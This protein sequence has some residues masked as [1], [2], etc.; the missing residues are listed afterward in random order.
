MSVVNVGAETPASADVAEQSRGRRLRALRKSRGWTQGRVAS[1]CDVHV[2]FISALETD[3]SAPGRDLLFRLARL[4]GVY[5]QFIETGVQ[6]PADS[7]RPG[8]GLS[9][10]CQGRHT[11]NQERYGMDSACSAAPVHVLID[12]GNEVGDSTRKTVDALL[13]MSR[14]T[15]ATRARLALESYLRISSEHAER[16]SMKQV[17]FDLVE[18]EELIARVRREAMPRMKNDFPEVVR[19]H[20]DVSA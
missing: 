4:F 13:D 5:P 6:A 14:A 11:G 9:R 20:I 10:S 15:M 7:N 19:D 1:E 17:H 3:A 18:I 12:A 8:G 16:F 2:S